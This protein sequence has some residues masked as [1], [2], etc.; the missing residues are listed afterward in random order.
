M[1]ETVPA[2]RRA[3]L[4]APP[5][6]PFPFLAAT[7]VAFDTGVQARTPE[8]LV[9]ALARLDAGVWFFHLIEEPWFAGGRTPL[10]EW[11]VT[12]GNS[13]LA[14]WLEQAVASG[15]P[16]DAARARLLRRWRRSRIGTRLAEAT[17]V[18]EATRRDAGRETVARLMRRR[19]ARDSA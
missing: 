8:E 5:G 15:L 18:P 12:R 17:A 11:L 10:L 14:A 13:R 3:H 1:L 16:L 6:S 4:D 19:R 7:S 9:E 2:S